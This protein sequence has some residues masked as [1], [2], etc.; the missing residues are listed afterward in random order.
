[1]RTNASINHINWN[2][3]SNKQNQLAVNL[4]Q[5]ETIPPYNPSGVLIA[6]VVNFFKCKLKN[7][8]NLWKKQVSW[9]QLPVHENYRWLM[10][11]CLF[12]LLI[13]VASVLASVSYST[14]RSWLWICN[15]LVQELIK[16]DWE[17]SQFIF[18]FYDNASYLKQKI[19]I[20]VENE[21]S[22]DLEK[23]SP[24]KP[25]GKPPVFDRQ[26]VIG[27][28]SC[29]QEEM[30]TTAPDTEVQQKKMISGKVIMK[31][32]YSRLLR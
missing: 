28:R 32:P 16:G 24:E 22:K 23:V 12:F 21:P 7:V 20:K 19:N 1:M 11:I 29:F 2:A 26:I 5:K 14:I 27:K 9:I 30:T 15:W 13:S 6:S 3:Y 25:P 4:K 17:P 10:R 18:A 31:E 8:P